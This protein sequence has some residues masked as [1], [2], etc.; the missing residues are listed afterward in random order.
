MSE[1]E[2]ARAAD[3][4]EIHYETTG[5]GPPLILVHG[6][7]ENR[8]AWDEFVPRFAAQ[9]TVTTLDLRGHGESSLAETYDIDAL[10]GDVRAVIEASGFSEP[11]L[12]GHSLGGI[13]ATAYAAAHPVRTI[14]NVDQALQLAELG[15]VV[16]EL[17]PALRGDGFQETM[18]ALMESLAGDRLSAARKAKLRELRGPARATV[19]LG[20][21]DPFLSNAGPDL[22]DLI[23]GLLGRIQAPYLA[24]HG[25][26]PGPGYA[27]WLRGLTP[28]AT[29]ETWDGFG[30]WLH[31]VDPDRF[32]K[33]ILRFLAS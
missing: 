6:I 27:D 12:V 22:T 13:V 9:Y 31:L 2:I 14:V 20:V 1:A 28:T 33:R 21:W 19:V 24:L 11:S 10:A 8:R 32:A 29:V 18:N 23:E 7:T 15:A 26:D 25:S 30:H 5:D 4:T 3:G 17:E 16:R